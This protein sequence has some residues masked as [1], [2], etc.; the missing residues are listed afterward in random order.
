MQLSKHKTQVLIPTLSLWP[1]LGSILSA[2]YLFFQ[3]LF[4]RQGWVLVVVH[5]LSHPAAYGILVLRPGMEPMSMALQGGFLTT[6]SQG[7]SCPQYILK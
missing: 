4:I 3:S 2:L 6:G 5:V 1:E 7:N